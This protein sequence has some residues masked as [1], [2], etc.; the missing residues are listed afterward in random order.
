MSH[1]VIQTVIIIKHVLSILNDDVYHCC[2]VTVRR[3]T[4]R[5]TENQ[6]EK[7]RQ[8]VVAKASKLFRK[9]GFDGIS[10]NDLMI[11]SGLHSGGFL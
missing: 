7:N 5:I 2:E 1:R 9:G 8:R 11:G 3:L 4:V 10:V 6:A